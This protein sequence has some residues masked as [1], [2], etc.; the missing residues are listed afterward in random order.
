MAGSSSRGKATVVPRIAPCESAAMPSP[1]L[2][3]SGLVLVVVLAGTAC[4]TSTSTSTG[5]PDAAPPSASPS[6]Q[7]TAASAAGAND[8]VVDLLHTIDTTVAVSSKVDNPHDRPEQLVDGKPETAWNGKTGDLSGYIAFRVPAAARVVRVEL[9]PGF[10]KKTA[11]GDLFTMNHRVRRVRLSREGQVLKEFALDVDD[12]GLQ[13]VDVDVPGGDFKL[14]VLETV[15]GSERAWK[16]LTVSEFRVWGRAGGSPPNP[17]RI[18]KMA[19]GS[20]D[21]VPPAKTFP[22][23]DLPRGPFPSIEKFCAA[24]DAVVFPSLLEKLGEDAMGGRK[25]ACSTGPSAITGFSAKDFEHPPFKGA[26][27]LVLDDL[28]ESRPTLMLETSKGWY[29]TDVV[30]GARHHMDPGCLRWPTTAIEDVQFQR[31]PTDNDVALVRIVE[32]EI[33]WAQLDAKQNG[34]RSTELGF[35]CRVDAE[36]APACEGP[37]KLATAFEPLPADFSPEHTT[38]QIIKPDAIPW[39]NRKTPALGLSG[40]FLGK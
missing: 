25:S 8:P 27:L 15:P 30:A 26:K 13:G 10:D 31:T 34:A 9:T 23:T 38:F 40:D 17:N 28:E 24:Y 4:R 16:E 7:A 36:G 29:R 1:I 20:L 32:R 5:A 33:L 14:D 6:T 12:R 3:R 19:I 39:Q 18:P 21:G 22:K 35:G 11:K 2:T 37:L